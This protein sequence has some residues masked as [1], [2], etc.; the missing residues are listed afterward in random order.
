MKT[1]LRKFKK[2]LGYSIISIGSI[3]WA[4]G[5]WFGNTNDELVS[6]IIIGFSFLIL[7]VF[8]ICGVG[9]IENNK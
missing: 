9:L 6:T 2:F 1:I 4:S 7:M 5:L 8:M 3:I